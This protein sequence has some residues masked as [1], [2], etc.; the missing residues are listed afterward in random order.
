MIGREPEAG[1]VPLAVGPAA[2]AAPDP[3][4]GG[5]AAAA[6]AGRSLRV[7]VSWSLVGNVVYLGCQYG[8]LM[9]I[10]KLGN[11][12]L[13]GRF[14]LAQAITAP[15]ILFSQMQLRQV[16]VTDVA[17]SA[18]FA[19]YFWT[20]VACTALAVA[21]ILA[22][23]A[24]TRF[25]RGAAVVVALVAVAKG[26]DSVSDIAYG[27]LQSRERMDLVAYSLV[28]K[29]I[30]S[31]AVLVALL[32]LTG[33][34][35]W[36]V[37]GLAAVWGGLLFVYDLPVRRRLGGEADPVLARLRPA[38]MKRLALTALPL[39]AFSGLTSLSG[40]LPRYFLEGMHGK[41]A[42]AIYSVAAAPLMLAGLLSG[43]ITQAVLPRAA[44]LFQSRQLEGLR[45]LTLRITL[46]QLATGIVFVAGLALFGGPLVSLLFTPEYRPAVPVMVTLALGVAVSALATHGSIVL[47]AGRR[48]G[49][50][51]ANIVLAV[52]VQVPL[53][54][55][56]VRPLG[57]GGAAW[58]EVAR[59][60]ASAV[61]LAVMGTAVYRAQSRGSVRQGAEA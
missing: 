26:F 51:L 38:V 9:A 41:E 7:G 59:T 10:A 12:V 61:F 11:P 47:M 58:S 16:Q 45:R 34:L 44:L 33:S 28:A 1:A 54:W 21:A 52:V 14:A 50:Q 43:S 13:V 23:V 22:F 3:D 6:P 46:F 15:V 48:F 49:L 18:R 17:G 55:L 57:A 5:L 42:V 25:D 2:G 27:K 20:R 30:L 37:A 32:K 60:A 24:V 19:D 8:M 35:E 40:N 29:G 53:C 4:G 31:L 36:A 56:L 39:A